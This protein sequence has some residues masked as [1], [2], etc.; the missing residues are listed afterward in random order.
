ME[1]SEI[2][3]VFRNIN[4]YL[5]FHR[6][7][8]KMKGDYE[9]ADIVQ[10]LLIDINNTVGEVLLYPNPVEGESNGKKTKRS[11]EFNQS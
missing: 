1:Q 7:E 5:I 11:Y 6:D 2:V 4:L 3:R 9:G 8:L 10:N